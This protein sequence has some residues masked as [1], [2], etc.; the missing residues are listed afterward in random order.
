MSQPASSATQPPVRPDAARQ[1]AAW[2][3][4][5]LIGAWMLYPILTPA[6]VEGFSASIVS[7]ALHL[8]DGHLA[9][10]DRLHPANLE[11]FTLSRLGTVTFVSVLTGPL[12][13]PGEWAIRLM[14]WLGFVALATSSFVLVR[15]W[16]N[17][18]SKAA[19]VALL[20]I[21]GLA[22]SS[23]FYNDTIFAAA[24]GTSAVAV[25]ATWP[26]L[27]A[28]AVSGVLLGAAIVARL[29]AVLLAPAV[30]LIGWE[31]HGLGRAFWSRASIFA[32]GVLVP[33]ILVQRSFMRA[34]ST[35]TPP[36]STPSSSGAS[37][38]DRRSMHEKCRCSS[39]SPPEF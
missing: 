39:A 24:L 37:R 4:I 13:L 19:V 14:T 12:R 23:F 38:F 17:A 1:A 10:Y 2:I 33:V 27:A 31:R 32:L 26:G 21:P 30:V 18:S 22:E 35:S 28:A 3:A 29:D 8:N 9:D 6:H 16:T 25:I 15:R 34:F 20:L 36:R 11:Y 5:I 7:L